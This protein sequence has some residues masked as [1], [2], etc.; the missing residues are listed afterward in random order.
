MYI[1]LTGYV[2]FDG[3]NIIE[4]LASVKSGEYDLTKNPWPSI[5]A[6]AKDLIRALLAYNPVDRI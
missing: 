2:P 5:S 1:L 6:E 4:I 3:N